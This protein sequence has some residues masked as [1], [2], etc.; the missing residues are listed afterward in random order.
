MKRVVGTP[1]VEG[2]RGSGEGGIDGATSWC[3]SSAWHALAWVRHVQGGLGVMQ[4]TPRASRS[5]TRIS[6]TNSVVSL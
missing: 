5:T 2:E 1:G 3:S 4:P 6:S